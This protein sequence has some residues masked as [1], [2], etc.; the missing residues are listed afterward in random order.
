[1]QKLLLT[2]CL[3]CSD[4]IVKPG[5][6]LTF[7]GDFYHRNAS[8]YSSI[9]FHNNFAIKLRLVSLRTKHLR[10][11]VTLK[12]FDIENIKQRLFLVFQFDPYTLQVFCFMFADFFIS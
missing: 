9:I 11:L 10:M 12:F 2:I 4:I 6:N 3:C 8:I 5:P 1:M 7:W